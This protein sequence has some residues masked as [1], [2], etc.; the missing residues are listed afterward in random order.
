MNDTNTLQAINQLKSE[1]AEM[2][3]NQNKSIDH[4]I[5]TVVEHVLS[6]SID[7]HTATK[8]QAIENITTK[9][10]LSV[11]QLTELTRQLITD[12]SDIKST[13]T[14]YALYDQMQTISKQFDGIKTDFNFVKITLDRMVAD[15]YI[16]YGIK[17][18]EL[19]KLYQ[20]SGCSPDEVANHFNISTQNLYKILNGSEKI[21]NDKRKHDL[22]Q[23]FIEK[24]Y[25]Q[26]HADV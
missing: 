3:K 8:K 21:P 25:K 10:P 18:E 9:G 1:V 20:S 7:F 16:E 6:K 13:N 24:I 4:R 19:E 17:A 11:D 23:F 14:N 26:N 22:K 5:N 2:F 15:K 12:V